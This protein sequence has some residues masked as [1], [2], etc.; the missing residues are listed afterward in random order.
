M[1]F[2]LFK[3]RVYGYLSYLNVTESK[4]I[5]SYIAK[6]YAELLESNT[7]C[8]RV[9]EYKELFDFMKKEPYLSFLNGAVGYYFAVSTLGIETDDQVAELAKLD[10]NRMLVFDACAN[11]F[12]EIK[13]DQLKNGLS[14]DISY[15]FCPGYQGSD[16]SDLEIILKELKADELGIT[17][18]ESGMMLPRKTMA[19]IYAKGVSPRKKCGNCLKLNDC[20]YRKAG[21][22]CFDLEK[23]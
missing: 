4:E 21:K 1:S 17:L 19:G 16:V 10:Q 6:V 8:Y 9:K 5:N 18:D 12:I 20:A 7:F 23:K 11:A 15:L 2:P 3:E 14:D 22:L 13:N